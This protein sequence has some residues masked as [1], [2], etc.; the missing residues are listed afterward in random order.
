MLT[1]AILEMV[2]VRLGVSVMQT[3]A[4]APALRAGDVQAVP[5]TA[6][7]IRR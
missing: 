7:D 5:I 4:I 3:R 2:K 1:D 6:S